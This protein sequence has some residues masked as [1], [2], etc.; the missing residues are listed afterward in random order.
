MSYASFQATHFTGHHFMSDVGCLHQWVQNNLFLNI[1][2]I[3]VKMS[4]SI[5]PPKL[6]KRISLHKQNP[7]AVIK[8]F[9]DEK[10]FFMGP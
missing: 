2:V 5:S 4:V 8:F 3:K 10:T 9:K 1:I 7:P 6:L